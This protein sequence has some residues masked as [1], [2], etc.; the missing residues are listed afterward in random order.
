MDRPKI[1]AKVGFGVLIKGFAPGAYTTITTGTST[2]LFSLD[3]PRTKIMYACMREYAV[4]VARVFHQRS[5]IPLGRAA[6][7]VR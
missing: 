3:I 4:H 2:A 7:C 5:Y 6:S 1:Y